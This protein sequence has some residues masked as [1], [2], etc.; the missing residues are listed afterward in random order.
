[1]IK[2]LQKVTVVWAK[3]ANIFA[4][5]FGE[6]ILKNHNIGPWSGFCETVSAKI[7][8]HEVT[9]GQAKIILFPEPEVE[10]PRQLQ[11]APPL[12]RVGHRIRDSPLRRLAPGPNP[13]LCRHLS[14]DLR[15]CCTQNPSSHT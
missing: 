14:V 12:R 11:A 3:N 8:G 15:F 13:I 1:M 10:A 7:Y 2:F 6:N 9:L 4:K 5:F